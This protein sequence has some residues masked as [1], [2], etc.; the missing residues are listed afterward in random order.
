MEHAAKILNH[1]VFLSNNISFVAYCQKSD[2]TIVIETNDITNVEIKVWA[3][4][5][6]I[7]S[8]TPLLTK[9]KTGQPAQFVVDNTNKLIVFDVVI[10]ELPIGDYQ[11][12]ISVTKTSWSETKIIYR[13]KIN[14]HSK[15]Y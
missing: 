15:V 12:T 6:D 10:D 14:K 1:N 9:N 13:G 11:Y 4:T 5:A 2:G 7:A 8:A 3:E